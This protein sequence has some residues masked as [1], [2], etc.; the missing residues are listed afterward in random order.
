MTLT[1]GPTD[2]HTKVEFTDWNKVR[3]F[4]SRLT[5]LAAGQGAPA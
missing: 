1:K 2:P 4:S 3:E 5:A